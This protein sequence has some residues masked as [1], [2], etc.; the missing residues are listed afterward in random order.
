MTISEIPS[1]PIAQILVADD[2]PDIRKL[3]ASAL[4]LEGYRILE[5]SDGRQAVDVALA[6]NPDLI[7]LD[8][9][10]PRLDG[11]EALAII[12]QHRKTRTTPVIML[13]ARGE[14]FDRVSGLSLGANDY[15]C[16]PFSIEE[17]RLRIDK[18]I[19]SLRQLRRLETMASAD[20]VSELGNRR[21]FGRAYDRWW[22]DH[23]R[24]SQPLSIVYAWVEGLETTVRNQPL[25][26]ADA[27][28]RR[29]GTGIRTCSREGEEVFDLGS[30]RYLLLTREIG[31][32]LLKRELDVQH[33]IERTLRSSARGS[34]SHVKSMSTTA[35][36]T[37]TK[38]SFL[39]RALG[40]SSLAAHQSDGSVDAST[41]RNSF[42]R[43]T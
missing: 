33:C 16:K 25:F 32:S 12:R 11:F 21:A 31:R 38:E 8:V 2:E 40:G 17:L 41:S 4:E 9:M 10:M 39:A 20:P 42:S 13:T 28:V 5:A 1:G 37:D 34:A 6:E 19:E 14:E 15:L 22:E 43:R 30:F 27:L 35:L 36:R 29:V 24:S 7:V 18:Q 26:A 3:V 23:Q